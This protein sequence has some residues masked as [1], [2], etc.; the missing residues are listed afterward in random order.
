MRSLR[1]ALSYL[2][3]RHDLVLPGDQLLDWQLRG[4][5]L[6]RTEPSVEVRRIGA[7]PRAAGRLLGPVRNLFALDGS[8]DAL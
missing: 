6:P 7:E 3:H 2:L 8:G 5:L 4:M 1:I